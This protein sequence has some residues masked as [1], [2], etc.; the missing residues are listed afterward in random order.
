MTNLETW[1]VRLLLAGLTRGTIL[2]SSTFQ[3]CEMGVVLLV[4]NVCCA[5][6]LKLVLLGKTAVKKWRSFLR[7]VSIKL[8]SM[9][10][11]KTLQS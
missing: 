3:L 9:I 6:E 2:S 7:D 5:Y 11:G 8:D 10:L 1:S 4:L